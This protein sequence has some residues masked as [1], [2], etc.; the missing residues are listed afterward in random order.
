M[1]PGLRRTPPSL[2]PQIESLSYQLFKRGPPE[3]PDVMDRIYV[4][5]KRLFVHRLV[6]SSTADFYIEAVIL[7]P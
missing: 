1:G 7:Q 6:P 3:G 5:R 4:V 2:F